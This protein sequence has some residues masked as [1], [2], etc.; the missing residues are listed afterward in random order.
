MTGWGGG[1]G[2]RVRVGGH[3][4][5]VLKPQDTSHPS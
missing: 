3:A 4:P 1:G 2:V 5:L